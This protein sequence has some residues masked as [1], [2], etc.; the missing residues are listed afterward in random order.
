MLIRFV[1]VCVCVDD[2]LKM[3]NEK[4]TTFSAVLDVTDPEPL[5]PGHALYTHDRVILTPHLSG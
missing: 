5:P 3:L 4:D 1:C 2:L